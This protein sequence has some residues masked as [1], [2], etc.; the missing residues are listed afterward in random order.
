MSRKSEEQTEF[1]Q[2]TL[3]T[4]LLEE[5]FHSIK[6]ANSILRQLFATEIALQNDAKCFSF[7]LNNSPRSLDFQIFALNFFS[8]RKTAWLE[9]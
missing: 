6:G 5:E 2:L 9:K 1:E 8:C 7:H 3:N 4:W